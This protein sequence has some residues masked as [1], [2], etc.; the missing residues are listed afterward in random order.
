MMAMPK[1]GVGVAIAKQGRVHNV[2]T[3]KPITT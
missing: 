2:P 1:E 3:S